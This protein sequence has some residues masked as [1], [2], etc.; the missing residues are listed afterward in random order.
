MN[1]QFYFK[2]PETA[3]RRARNAALTGKGAYCYA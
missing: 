2:S 1:T 3:Y